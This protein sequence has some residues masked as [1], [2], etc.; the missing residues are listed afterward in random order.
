[1]RQVARDSAKQI[2]CDVGH[3]ANVKAKLRLLLTSEICDVVHMSH[4]GMPTERSIDEQLERKTMSKRAN[5]GS[6]RNGGR[7]ENCGIRKR[8]KMPRLV[9]LTKKKQ[10]PR[11]ESKGGERGIGRYIESKCETVV[12]LA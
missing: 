10:R 1:V 5:R 6:S 3:S 7:F 2:I 11:S 4:D 9:R 8:K 12:L